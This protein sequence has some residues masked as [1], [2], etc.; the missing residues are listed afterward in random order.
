MQIM[1]YRGREFIVDTYK[2]EAYL[3]PIEHNNSTSVILATD[4]PFILQ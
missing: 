3:L 4:S 2:D 1:T